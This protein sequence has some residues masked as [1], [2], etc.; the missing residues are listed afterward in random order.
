MPESPVR[1]VVANDDHI[2]IEGLRSM[3][4]S[5]SDDVVVVGTAEAIPR[6]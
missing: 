5:Y 2:I 3:L 1:V 4:A 6:S